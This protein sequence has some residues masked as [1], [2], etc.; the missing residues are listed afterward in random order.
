MVGATTVKSKL[1]SEARIIKMPCSNVTETK[2]TTAL[3]ACGARLKAAPLFSYFTRCVPI[4]ANILVFMMLAL[5]IR[6][7]TP[8]P[9]NIRVSCSSLYIFY[10]E[11]SADLQSPPP[12]R[13]RPQK[14]NHLC[15]IAGK[16]LQCLGKVRVQFQVGVHKIQRTVGQMKSSRNGS[17][18]SIQK[19]SGINNDR[20]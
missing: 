11:H 16:H 2:E 4:W 18:E 5:G 14:T 9:L 8:P 19:Y 3:C 12:L 1:S 10:P 13:G 20:F 7:L 6:M 15:T 17:R